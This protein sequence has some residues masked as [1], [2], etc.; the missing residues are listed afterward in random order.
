MHTAR[1]S[2]TGAPDTGAGARGQDPGD[3]GPAGPRVPDW[4]TQIP[5]LL[6]L[7]GVGTGLIIVAMAHFRRGPALVAAALFLGAGLR[8]LLPERMVGMLAVRKRWVDVAT[9]VALAVGLV[10]FAL[11]APQMYG[12]SVPLWEFLNE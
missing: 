12:A 4:I 5:Y 8:A 6:V 11:V 10:V 1:R 9:L 7:L 3:G 2:D